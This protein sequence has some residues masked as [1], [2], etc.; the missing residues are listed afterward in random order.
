M[1]RYSHLTHGRRIAVRQYPCIC[2]WTVLGAQRAQE[3]RHEREWRSHGA[4][5][6][7][8]TTSPQPALLLRPAD[9]TSAV[10]EGTFDAICGPQALDRDARPRHAGSVAVQ[11]HSADSEV[12]RRA[13]PGLLPRVLVVALLQPPAGS[14]RGWRLSVDSCWDQPRAAGG[15]Q[16]AAAKPAAATQQQQP[17]SKP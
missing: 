14:N 7:G 5:C 2:A 8:L 12:G 6:V 9:A 1:R 15:S 3:R 13:G 17:S 11:A 16:A 10:I 4:R